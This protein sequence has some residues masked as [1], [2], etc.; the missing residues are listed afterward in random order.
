MDLFK[1]YL[2]SMIPSHL[3]IMKRRNRIRSLISAAGWILL[4]YLCATAIPLQTKTVAREKPDW[5][6]KIVQGSQLTV[7]EL[8]RQILPDIKSDPN[9]QDKITASDLSGIRLLDGVEAT[10]MELH[11]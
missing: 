9:K 10:G 7:L 11:P 3:R 2:R 6:D 5:E 8:A 4:L 1:P